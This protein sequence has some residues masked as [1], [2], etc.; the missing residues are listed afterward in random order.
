MSTRHTPQRQIIKP[1]G[2]VSVFFYH[3]L[4]RDLFLLVLLLWRWTFCLF[5]LLLFL[6]YFVVVVFLCFL[7]FV[8]FA[9]LQCRTLRIQQAFF[10]SFLKLF[11][12][13]ILR[14][15]GSRDQWKARL[16]CENI[17][18][19]PGLTL[20]SHTKSRQK[21]VPEPHTSPSVNGNARPPPSSLETRSSFAGTDFKVDPCMAHLPTRTPSLVSS[22]N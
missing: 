19:A 4:I 12:R 8:L 5:V 9:A 6:V 16:G 3:L 10:F 22:A 21:P 7:L 13:A 17:S 20:V 2:Q 15:C 11:A 14:Y 1:A 18:R